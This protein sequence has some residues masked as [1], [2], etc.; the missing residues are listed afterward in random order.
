M[1]LTNTAAPPNAQANRYI[2]NWVKKYRVL[3]PRASTFFCQKDLPLIEKT[4]ALLSPRQ[5]SNEKTSHLRTE[6]QD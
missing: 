2:A 5:S 1:P 4:V 3:D 6:H